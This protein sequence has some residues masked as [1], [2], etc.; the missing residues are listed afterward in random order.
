MSF[1]IITYCDC[2]VRVAAA[3]RLAIIGRLS[4]S[5]AFRAREGAGKK[6]GTTYEL[7]YILESSYCR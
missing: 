4:W 2:F 6:A 1:V 7:R 3:L 5:Q